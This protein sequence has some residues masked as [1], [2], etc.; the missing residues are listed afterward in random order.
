MAPTPP[1]TPGSSRISRSEGVEYA[2]VDLKE[3]AVRSRDWGLGTGNAKFDITHCNVRR[4]STRNTGAKAELGREGH[5]R[6]LEQVLSDRR[7]VQETVIAMTYDAPE[8]NLKK[9]FRP[10]FTVDVASGYDVPHQLDEVASKRRR[11]ESSLELVA[12]PTHL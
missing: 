12:A 10:A 11:A 2:L 5:W 8:L 6:H 1:S 3:V 7:G 4:E 9:A